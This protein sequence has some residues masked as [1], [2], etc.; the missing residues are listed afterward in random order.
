MCF[1]WLWYLWLEGI[2][3]LLNLNWCFNLNIWLCVT[4][5]KKL[6]NLPLFFS[7]YLYW[8]SVSLEPSF[9][10][11][12]VLNCVCLRLFKHINYISLRHLLNRLLLIWVKI[13]GFWLALYRSCRWVTCEV[14]IKSIACLIG[15]I[16]W[17]REE[18]K[19]RWYWLLC[20]LSWSKVK[21]KAW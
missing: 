5:C 3:L 12:K 2:W 1:N 21:L 4:C 15:L 18:I 19:T 17:G 14:E 6:L 9:D 20:H 16:R 13:K 7:L 8:A 10:I 11:E